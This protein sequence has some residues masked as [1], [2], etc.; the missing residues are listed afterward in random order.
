MTDR[1]D[2][3]EG[4]EVLAGL[5][6]F[7]AMHPEW[8]E[9]EGGDE[10]WEQTVAW[11][12]ISSPQGL[13]LVDPLVFDWTELDRLVA[14]QGSVA[15]IARTC[16]WHQRSIAEVATHYGAEVWAKPPPTGEPRYRFDRL[17]TGEEPM[18]GG[19]LAFDVE[20]NDEFA[21]WIPN[22]SA[23]LF[24]DVLLRSPNGKPRRCPDTWIQP[25]GGPARLRAVLGGL[26]R[27]PVEHVLVSHGPLVLGDGA[28][29]LEAAIR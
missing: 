18:P 8:T 6:R 19:L 28:A 12:A 27:L 22:H 20:R 3:A 10:G 29:A 25:A 21:L 2:K 4:T 16:H 11:W 26:T 24:G 23:L 9:D 14:A 5:W 15:G 1:P 17:A 13:I 7:E